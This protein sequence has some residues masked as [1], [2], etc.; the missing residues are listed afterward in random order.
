MGSVQRF[1]LGEGSNKWDVMYTVQNDQCD[2]YGHSGANGICRIDNRP[3]VSAWI[4]LFQNQRVNGNS[5]IGPVA[6]LGHH[7]IAKRGKGLSNLV[8]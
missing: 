3:I 6:T 2:N 1:V 5:L 7:W 8:V 4:G